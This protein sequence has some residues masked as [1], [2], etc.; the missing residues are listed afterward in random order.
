MTLTIPARISSLVPL[1]MILL[2]A[3][4]AGAEEVA[5]HS[6]EIPMAVTYQ[7]INFV[8][9]IGLLVYFLRKP[10]K[11]FFSTREQ[12]YKQALVKAESARKDAERRKH[13]V[14][15]RLNSL[16]LSANE[17]LADARAEAAAI[18]KQIQ[19]E[20]TVLAQ[21]LRD[22][23][24]RSAELEIERAKSELRDEMLVQSVALAKKLLQDK[25]AEPDQKRLQTEFVDKIQEV[26]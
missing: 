26:R 23:A 6:V 8:I 20:A 14:E 2:I 4:P 18:K 10:I 21:R 15:Q 3:G 25:I 5:G 1:L 19:E 7:V 13:E 11:N 22:E 24:S 16:E 17:T 12:V 9:Y